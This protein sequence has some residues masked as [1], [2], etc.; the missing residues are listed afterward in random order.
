VGPQ[1]VERMARKVSQRQ[2]PACHS[3]P[4]L[5]SSKSLVADGPRQHCE[6]P[7]AAGP[8]APLHELPSTGRGGSQPWEQY[9]ELQGFSSPPLCKK[10]GH[11]GSSV[12]SPAGS[13][14]QHSLFGH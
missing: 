3:R 4:L 12:V 13:P 1:M 6:K 5:Q 7:S 11:A 8:E 2:K 14:H 10:K 9:R